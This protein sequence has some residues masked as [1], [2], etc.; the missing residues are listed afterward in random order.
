MIEINDE[1]IRHVFRHPSHPFPVKPRQ[2][3]ALRVLSQFGEETT[4]AV[5]EK[6]GAFL[7]P[8]QFR[9]LRPRPLDHALKL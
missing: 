6:M 5:E 3:I 2:E 7:R 9:H 1:A 4:K 8:D